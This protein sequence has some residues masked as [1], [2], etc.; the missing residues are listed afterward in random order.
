MKLVDHKEL[1]RLMDGQGKSV[2]GLGARVGLGKST[3]ARLR[4]GEHKSTSE[5]V[6][7]AIERELQVA[8]GTLFVVPRVPCNCACHGTVAA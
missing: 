4:R 8:P 2:R 6:A 5:D 7:K 1:A 3:M